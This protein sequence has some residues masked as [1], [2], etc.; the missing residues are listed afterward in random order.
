MMTVFSRRPCAFK[1]VVRAY[2][3]A[4]DALVRRYPDRYRRAS[5]G[6]LRG[7]FRPDLKKTFNR[8]YTE[9]FL[10]GKRGE[11]AAMDAPKSMGEYI[12]TVDR[13]RAGVVTVRPDRPSLAPPQWRRLRFRGP[14]RRHRR[15]PG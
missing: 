3:D 15:F 4:L 6:S 2:S 1:N 11:W 10:D 14:G 9:L 8:D 13:L 7:G 12:G 5:Y